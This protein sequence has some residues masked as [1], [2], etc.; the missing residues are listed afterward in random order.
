MDENVK[1]AMEKWPNVP[2]CYGWL[3]LDARGAWHMRDEQAQ[4]ADTHGDKIEH[5]ALLAFI[6]RNYACDDQGRWFFQNGPQRV[7][8]NLEATPY[9][10][11][12]DATKKFQLHTGE[13]LEQID[14]AWF[15]AGGQ[16]LL[17]SQDRIAQV[18]D[19]DL[20][21]VLPSLKVHG[22]PIDDT[23]LLKWVAGTDDGSEAPALVYNDR[24]ITL[25]RIAA[26]D[27]TQQFAFVRQPRPDGVE[28]VSPKM[29]EI[30]AAAVAEPETEHLQK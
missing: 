4:Q 3:M 27:V 28:P 24:S 22:V 12:T 15:T 6:N 11:R 26:E 5:E 25:R 9:I 23:Q 10:A 13:I 7:F 14:A 17:Q 18:D 16:L 21:Q 8:V 1:K 19:R 2:N 20:V 30:V 29:A